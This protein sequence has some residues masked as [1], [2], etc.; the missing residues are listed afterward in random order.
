MVNHELSDCFQGG[1]FCGE[2]R[3]EGSEVSV[4]ALHIR[5]LRMEGR[6][7][8]GS[9]DVSAQEF[10]QAPQAAAMYFCP[11]TGVLNR[12]PWPVRL[13]MAT[14]SSTRMSIPIFRVA[15]VA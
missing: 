13:S 1:F 15:M 3:L 2:A 7:L 14:P 12:P 9:K 5:L 10:F 4:K 8:G 11:T 6:A